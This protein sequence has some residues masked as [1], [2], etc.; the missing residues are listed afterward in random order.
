MVLTATMF[1]ISR[2]FL[3]RTVSPDDRC[4]LWLEKSRFWNACQIQPAVLRELINDMILQLWLYS[5]AFLQYISTVLFIIS[6]LHLTSEFC[7][8]L[9]LVNVFIMGVN[10]S[11]QF[12]VWS[13][14]AQMHS[15]TVGTYRLSSIVVYL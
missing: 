12:L 2:Q 6:N 13:A 4:A 15:S 9:Q 3:C 11:A 10:I 8:L 7:G 1:S 5:G 14:R